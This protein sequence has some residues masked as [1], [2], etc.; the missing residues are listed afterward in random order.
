ML[1]NFWYACE[2]SSRVDKGPRGVRL[3]GRDLV[4][5]RDREGA[6]H[7]LDG[8]CVHRGGPLADGRV[9]GACVRCPYHGWLYGPD[10]ACLEIPSQARDLP[11]PARARVDA[12][13]VRERYGWI[14]VFVGDIAAAERP[15]L[16][17]FSEAED[18]GWRC[19]QGEFHWQAHVGRV[20]ENALDIAHAAFVHVGTFGNP[21]QPEVERLDLQEGAWGA[22][23]TTRVMAR[24][25]GG[26][27]RLLGLAPDW[28]EFTLGFHMPGITRLEIRLDRFAAV[29]MMANVPVDETT[30]RTLYTQARNAMTSS[31]ADYGSRRQLL[32]VFEED[33]PIVEAVRP[34][35]MPTKLT[36]EVSVR[37][38]RLGIA[39]RKRVQALME[40]GWGIDSD[41]AR[42]T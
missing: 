11:I 35:R 40:R 32:K 15:P 34:K 28:V 41:W 26:L 7:A 37:A 42:P 1:K 27:L 4:V 8:R 20:V 18:P 36:D 14:W 22:Q 13:P 31:W 21:S 38:D 9:E 17:E 6:A 16:P 29:L 33:R 3:M 19:I 23:V 10:G 30:T 25:R 12:L 24:R 39:Y 5:Y 2:M